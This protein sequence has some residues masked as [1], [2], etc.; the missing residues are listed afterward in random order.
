MEVLESAI[1]RGIR[2]VW[3]QQKSDTPQVLEKARQH[4]IDLIYGECIMMHTDPTS[5]VHKFH[6]TIR[7]FFGMLPK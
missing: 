7:R 5:G 4:G 3:I 2:N 6:K 1:N